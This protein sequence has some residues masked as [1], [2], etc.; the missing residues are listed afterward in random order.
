MKAFFTIGDGT[1]RAVDGTPYN[2]TSFGLPSNDDTRYG[3]ISDGTSNLYSGRAIEQL[4]YTWNNL[5]S[6]AF[7]NLTIAGNPAN[8]GWTTL[9]VNGTAYLRADAAFRPISTAVLTGFG[10]PTTATTT[11]RRL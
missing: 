5:Y 2:F 9:T 11:W 10:A 3:S 8:S 1:G 6:T 7:L 4:F